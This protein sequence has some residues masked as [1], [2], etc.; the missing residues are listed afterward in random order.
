M[1]HPI[2]IGKRFREIIFG[3]IDVIKT[4]MIDQWLL[5]GA[6]AAGKRDKGTF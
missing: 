6:C 3:F 1:R 2:Y 5:L 4:P